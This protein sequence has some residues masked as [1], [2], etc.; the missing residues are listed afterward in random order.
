MNSAIRV[1]FAPSPTGFMHLGSVRTALLNYLFAQ[2]KQGTF[3]LRIEDTDASRN[4]EAARLGILRDMAWLGLPY[5]EGPEVGGH[6]GP[7]YQSQRDAI[8]QEHLQTLIADCKAYRCF[9]SA[10]DLDAKREKQIAMGKPPRY[11]RT[12]LGYS[13]DKI[14]AK[15]AANIPFVW[16]FNLNQDQMVQIQDIARGTISFELKNF[17][18]FSLTRPDGTCTFMFVNFI[19]DWLMRITHVIRGEDHLTNTALQAALYDAFRVPQPKFWHL[20]IIC[21]AFGE[22]LSKR[23]FGFSLDDLRNEGFLPHAIN[24]Y[25]GTVGVSFAEEIQDLT[26]LANNYT[27]DNLHAAGGVRYDVEKLTWFNHKWIG[28]LDE[29]ELYKHIKPFLHQAYAQTIT[30]PEAEALMLINK[31]RSELYR[32]TDIK[33]ALQFYFAEPVID[34]SKLEVLLGAEKIT[35]LKGIVQSAQEHIATP[36]LFVKTVKDS[37]VAQGFKVKEI[38]SSL[39]YLLTGSFEG[40]GIV[41]LVTLLDAATVTKRLDALRG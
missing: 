14:K 39:R 3:V 33:T 11:D 2:K 22:K 41:D 20:Q 7:Y 27:F 26:Q 9:C 40:I 8:Y 24:N 13:A 38:F 29:H 34:Y 25:M 10:Q 23:D 12:C 37:G 32:L 21:N 28:R 31:V 16:R 36:D 5:H 1:R 19:D 30:M 17:S 4:L 6:Y 35:S 15:L 18:D